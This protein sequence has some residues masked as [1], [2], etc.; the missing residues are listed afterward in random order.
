MWNCGLLLKMSG[1]VYIETLHIH[2]MYTLWRVIYLQCGARCF[3]ISG[4]NWPVYGRCTKSEL[5]YN[6]VLSRK[7]NDVTETTSPRL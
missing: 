3:L 1:T 7:Q 5:L 6:F 2:Y 4:A